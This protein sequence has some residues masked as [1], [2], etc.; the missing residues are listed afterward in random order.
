MAHNDTSATE[1]GASIR[2]IVLYPIEPYLAIVLVLLTVGCF[3]W[4]AFF[5][6]KFN[7]RQRSVRDEES[8][9]SS[10]RGTSIFNLP[11][12]VINFY[13]VLAFRTMVGFRS[14]VFNLAEL[15]A[16]VAYVVLLFVW[17]FIISNFSCRLVHLSECLCRF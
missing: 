2:G 6:T 1:T 8:V 4:G 17:T 10:Q 5:L 9:R 14:Y 7:S 3:Q 11:L 15:F 13:R 12:A 16:A